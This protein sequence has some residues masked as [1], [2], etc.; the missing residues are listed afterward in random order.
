MRASELD[1]ELPPDL[2]AARPAE[3]RDSARLLVVSRSDPSRLEHRL[4][5][6]LPGLLRPGDLLV[7]NTTR[8]IPA[9]IRGRRARTGG[10]VEGLYLRDAG[11]GRWVVFLQGRRLKTGVVVEL[12]DA[13]GGASGVTLTV[14][15]PAPAD[16]GAWEVSVEGAL[17]GAG[18]LALLE[19]L[20]STPLPPYIRR[21]RAQAGLTIVD[22]FDRARYQTVYAREGGSVAAPTAGLH[23]TPDLLATLAAAGIGRA[24][25]LLDVGAG[26]F[27]PVSTELVEDHPMHAEWCLMPPEAEAA[28]E[29][30]R[31]AGGRVIPVGTTA[32]RTIE[33]FALAPGHPADAWLETRL[34]I[35]PGFAWRRTDGLLTNFHLPR[36]TLLALVAALFPEG[37][38]RVRAIYAEAIARRYR[39]YSYG[40]AMLILP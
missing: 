37:M 5:R 12:D 22:E 32:A 20:G 2:I 39:F 36:S 11:P 13:A 9:L 1:F 16:P 19:R 38:E 10:R 28:I 4:V 40:D 15:A 25:V 8:V 27:K 29:R 33:S 18:A 31:A 21:A 23:F 17:A 30:A 6:D 3:P 34:L 7:F 35:A 26:T 14:L 24:D